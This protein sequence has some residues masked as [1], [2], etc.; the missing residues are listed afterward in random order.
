MKLWVC[1]VIAVGVLIA[2]VLLISIVDYLQERDM[3]WVLGVIVIV[4]ALTGYIW[5]ASHY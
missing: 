3:G 4:I 5:L 1:F 2:A